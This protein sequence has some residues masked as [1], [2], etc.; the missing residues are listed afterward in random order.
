[1]RNERV[2]WGYEYESRDHY[3]VEAASIASEQHPER[4]ED[5][6][7]ILESGAIGVFD[8]VG[9]SEGS[10]AASRFVAQ[11]CQDALKDARLADSPEYVCSELEDAL[12]DAQHTL[13]EVYFD[14][15]PSIA[16]TAAL[17]VIAHDPVRG[18]R[19]ACISYAG[20]TRGYIF[21]DGRIVAQTLDHAMYTPDTEDGQREVQYVLSHAHF[22][23]EVPKDYGLYRY[24]RNMIG[25]YVDTHPLA[26]GLKISSL[27]IPV[28]PGDIVLLTSDGVHDNLTD[29][30]IEE[31]VANGGDISAHLADAALTRSREPSDVIEIINGREKERYNFRSKPDDITAAVL[32][33]D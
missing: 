12:R 2:A 18:E 8:G 20:D 14:S 26:R 32:Y 11:Y 9:G 28:R 15:G 3:R 30:E 29:D 10:E 31:I 7:F 24:H 16:T 22:I 5:S 33:C 23:D 27:H 4:N 25:S 19:H 6:Y 17:A 13:S 1:M 21:R